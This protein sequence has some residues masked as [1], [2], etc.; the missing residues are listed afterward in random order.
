MA[1]QAM[2]FQRIAAPKGEVCEFSIERYRKETRRLLEMLDVRLGEMRGRVKEMRGRVKSVK[3]ESGANHMN[4]TINTSSS[5]SEGKVDSD[6]DVEVY[7]MGP[8]YTIVDIACWTYA[9]ISFWA[10]VGFDDLTNLKSWILRIKKRPAVERGIKVPSAN[11]LFFG[12]G[13]AEELEKAVEVNA[14]KF[15]S[16]YG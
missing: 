16:K 14:G 1:G 9:A 13:N 2:Y 10:N 6:T 5:D 15:R 8:S 11:P 12:E 7:L 3:S 4:N